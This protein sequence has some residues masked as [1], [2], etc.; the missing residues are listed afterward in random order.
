MNTI[1]MLRVSSLALLCIVFL[2]G[3]GYTETGAWVRLAHPGGLPAFHL[4]LPHAKTLS[5][6]VCILSASLYD[7]DAPAL[8]QLLFALLPQA[9]AEIPRAEL[10]RI[11]DEGGIHISGQSG[12]DYSQLAVAATRDEAA[13]ALALLSSLLQKPSQDESLYQETRTQL[14][15][16]FLRE[17]GQPYESL[18]RGLKKTILAGHPY[19]PWYA[20]EASALEGI[21]LARVLQHH[22]KIMA[23]RKIFI[24]SCGPQTPDEM[25]KI[26]QPFASNQ[27]DE[28]IPPFPAAARDAQGKSPLTLF[29]HTAANSPYLKAEYAAPAPGSADYPVSL[30][31]ARVLSAML[32]ESVRTERGLVYSV[33]AGASSGRRASSA[34][35][36][37][38]RCRDIQAAVSAMR[39]TIRALQEGRASVRGAGSTE[40]DESL[41]PLRLAEAVEAAKNQLASALAMQAIAPR[42]ISASF[43][44]WYAASGE[45]SGQSKLLEGIARVRP[46]D[47]R[48]L[49]LRSFSD[50]H[51]GIAYDPASM[52]PPSLD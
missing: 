43:A 35:L 11:K 29:P 36:V 10:D 13:R 37:L 1:K 31:M 20:L 16:E 3:A 9:G 25:E 24:V 18:D 38:Y 44:A 28:T 17:E 4:S 32:M 21:P 6:R 49:A 23:E 22:K 33:W 48:A 19:G 34:G 12:L 50:M 14:I 5:V 52:D 46:E 41:P 47:V 26:I 2:G 7:A 42:D 45:A 8:D 51:W 15:N 39:E 27:K 40:A 30:V